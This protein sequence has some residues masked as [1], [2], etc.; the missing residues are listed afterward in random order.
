MTRHANFWSLHCRRNCSYLFQT[1]VSKHCGCTPRGARGVKRPEILGNGQKWGHVPIAL[2]VP[3]VLRISRHGL[4]MSPD[5]PGGMVW[6]L[7]GT[8]LYGGHDLT[9]ALVG[10]WLKNL[11]KYG[12]DI[13]Q[14]SPYVPSGLG[15]WMEHQC[16]IFYGLQNLA[17]TT[18]K[19]LKRSPAVRCL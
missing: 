2:P 4:G 13:S 17:P 7:V 5:R 3:Q 11:S 18:A 6:M 19:S 8:S 10:I 1:V 15:P 9:P 16:I 12:W 14:T